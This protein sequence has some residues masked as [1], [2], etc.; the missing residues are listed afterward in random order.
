M[1]APARL[2][3]F[4]AGLAV[5]FVGAFALAGAIVPASAVADWQRQAPGTAD[6]GATDHDADHDPGTT[7][8]KDETMTTIQGVSL[9]ANGWALSPV[10]APAG[11]GEAGILAFRILDEQGEPLTRF[12]TT[13]ERELHLIVVRS[14]GARFEHV[15]PQLDAQTGVWSIAW[16]WDAAGSYR[17]FADFAPAVGD[18]AGVT[19]SR[20]VDV[21]GD[22]E[23]VVA[24]GETRRD[25]V[26][27]FEVSIEGSL[28][29]GAASQLALTV[30]KD[31][32]PVAELQPYL[33]AFGHLVALRDGDLAFL[34][35]H[36]EGDAPSPGATAGPT[37]RFVATTPTAGRYLLFLDFQVDGVV[38]TAEF[39]LDAAAPSGAA[40]GS[41]A[42]A[43]TSTPDHDGH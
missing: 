35:V 41:V 32:R 7:D 37:I 42:P 14:D 34:H 21:A 40:T 23:P 20:T 28:V 2:A 4:A 24:T 18:T 39:V 13:H 19:L 27:G 9:S 8:P 36:A 31:G 17:V 12:T 22:V 1:N 6:P 15:H 11:V 38:R 16:E 33:G 26:D 25:Q 30:T 5:A 29:A 10:E 3:L 43:P